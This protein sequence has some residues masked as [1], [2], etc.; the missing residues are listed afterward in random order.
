[1]FRLFTIFASYIDDF[2]IQDFSS[3]NVEHQFLGQEFEYTDPQT[4]LVETI[5][6]LI[7][8]FLM[9]LVVVGA[10]VIITASGIRYIVSSGNEEQMEHAKK[11]LIYGIFGFVIAIMSWTIIQVTVSVIE[12]ISKDQAH[13]IVTTGTGGDYGMQIAGVPDDVLDDPETQ[14]KWYADN[15]ELPECDG[16]KTCNHTFSTPGNHELKVI[17]TPKGGTPVTDIQKIYV[18][19]SGEATLKATLDGRD[20]LL[21]LE[22]IDDQQ[23]QSVTWNLGDGSAPVICPGG[24][25]C[26]GINIR[27]NYAAAGDYTVSA[28][29][30]NKDNTTIEVPAQPVTM[31]ETGDFWIEAQDGATDFEKLLVLHGHEPS[32]FESMLVHWGTSNGDEDTYNL[33][34]TPYTFPRSGQ[35]TVT[36]TV[37]YKSGFEADAPQSALSAVIDITTTPEF[38]CEDPEG[39]NV[40]CS[41]VN[42]NEAAMD[43]ITWK[44]DGTP[45]S[46]CNDGG[47]YD[48]CEH[49][50][51]DDTEPHTLSAEITYDSYPEGGSAT[52]TI[53][54]EYNFEEGA[55][56][57]EFTATEAKDNQTGKSAVFMYE[58]T[59]SN[60]NPD[61]VDVA[62]SPFTVD[63]KG[64][65]NYVPIEDYDDPAD[66]QISWSYSYDTPGVYTT[67]V[68]VNYKDTVDPDPVSA[69]VSIINP[70]TQG[71]GITIEFSTTGGIKRAEIKNFGILKET[72]KIEANI[73]PPGLKRLILD[74]TGPAIIPE[75]LDENTAYTIDASIFYENGTTYTAHVEEEPIVNEE[76]VIETT[77]YQT[78]NNPANN[79]P[80]NYSFTLSYT[81]VSACEKIFTLTGLQSG[82]IGTLNGDFI[83][84]DP[85]TGTT[86]EVIM[87]NRHRT[88]L[89][90]SDKYV[91][92]HTFG[93]E[94]DKPVQVKMYIKFPFEQADGT[95][96]TITDL[97][98]LNGIV[99]PTGCGR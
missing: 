91:F 31:P 86:S 63:Y 60:F 22:D 17:V 90:G 92:N 2:H 62:N 54:K 28:T 83:S 69:D 59:L 88:I 57:I 82:D 61:K 84:N 65:G 75:N 21:T 50:F 23:V 16:E 39:T 66:R 11:T 74:K 64:T 8:K 15:E 29:I 93:S 77:K 9:P 72:D 25:G 41:I 78:Q 38:D 10:L 81:D 56:A 51:E 34:V 32:K 79:A 55:G 1:M 20:M 95:I 71:E 42:Y 48:F 36:A 43:N 46:V 35:Y 33:D 96:L 49:D 30:T 58:F 4:S 45:L 97:V 94:M 53:E 99:S 52:E 12:N 37:S 27:H 80:Y 85:S 44:G 68:K 67:K 18:P 6:N 40:I 19:G 13:I 24:D 3:S 73:T 26:Q 14:I 47:P 87:D 89:D 76:H 5:A 7:G 98:T 70:E